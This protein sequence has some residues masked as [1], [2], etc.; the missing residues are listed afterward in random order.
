M[1]DRLPLVQE[2]PDPA[3]LQ[4]YVDWVLGMQHKVET[5]VAAVHSRGVVIRDLHPS[6]LIVRPDGHVVLIDLE[7]ATSVDDARRQSLADPHFLAPGE[8]TGAAID[9]YALACLRIFLF[10]PL[11]ALVA[12]SPGRAAALATVV[13]NSHPVPP[14]FLDDAVA[15][16]EA[17]WGGGERHVDAPTEPPLR[18]PIV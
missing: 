13:K 15:T 14:G 12:L 1:A 5:V 6:N 18:D 10:L 9:E 16:I 17:A 2:R 8:T 4:Q 7:I 11:T 3:T